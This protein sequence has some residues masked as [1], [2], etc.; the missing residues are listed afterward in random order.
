MNQ[1]IA[2][3]A[4]QATTNTVILILCSVPSKSLGEKIA[5]HLVERHFAAC[6]NIIP[7]ITSIYRWNNKVENS[8]ELLLLIKSSMERLADISEYI[9]SVH[10]YD[11]PEILAIPSSGGSMEYLDWIIHETKHGFR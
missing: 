7:K 2:L 1:Q 8:E 11:L 6:V 10:P 5:T 3:S 4:P 9:R